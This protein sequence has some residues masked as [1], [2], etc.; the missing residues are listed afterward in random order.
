MS[1]DCPEGMYDLVL[2]NRRPPYDIGGGVKDALQAT[3]GT[4]V[5]VTTDE[6]M[7]S[8]MLF[9][10]REGIDVAPAAAIAIAALDKQ[11]RSGAV[12]KSDRVLLNITGGGEAHLHREI[13]TKKLPCNLRVDAE[14]VDLKALAGWAHDYL[15]K[16]K[17]QK[18]GRT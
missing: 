5:G 6:A 15:G 4:V 9:A 16:R 17:E 3:H 13:G 2:Y 12:K 14:K 18:G 1:D 7:V 8:R 10:D 11:A